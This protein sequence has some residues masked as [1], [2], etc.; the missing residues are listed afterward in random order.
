MSLNRWVDVCGWNTREQLK[1]TN[2]WISWQLGWLQTHAAEWRH[3]SQKVNLHDLLKKTKLQRWGNRWMFSRGL[4]WRK[5]LN[6]K[7]KLK[8]S[9]RVMGCLV[10]TSRWPPLAFLCPVPSRRESQL[11]SPSA[12]TPTLRAGPGPAPCLCRA[13]SRPFESSWRFPCREMPANQSPLFHFREAGENSGV[14][15]R[16]VT[17]PHPVRSR[18]LPGL[19]RSQRKGA[20]NRW[21]SPLFTISKINGV[22]RKTLYLMS[23]NMELIG[24]WKDI[25]SCSLRLKRALWMNPLTETE[26]WKRLFEVQ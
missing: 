26:F 10:S 11:T 16:D 12:Q 18:C 23:Q 3:Q 2:D 24:F 6:T 17:G 7:G 4:D 25:A 22:Q 9:F 5:G 14:C 15:L 13:P 19:Q 1:G 20:A 21:V 8:G